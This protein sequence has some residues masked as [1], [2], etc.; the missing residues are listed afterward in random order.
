[1]LIWLSYVCQWKRGLS[2]SKRLSY[3]DPP[4]DSCVHSGFTSPFQSTGTNHNSLVKTVRISHSQHLLPTRSFMMQNVGNLSLHEDT[5]DCLRH[6]LE[7]VHAWVFS[8]T[9]RIHKQLHVTCFT[10][11]SSKSVEY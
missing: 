9:S 10:G 3:Q 6:P 4:M 7:V 8:L 11:C 5:R 2:A 1:M